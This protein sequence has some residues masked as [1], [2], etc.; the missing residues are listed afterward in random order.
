MNIGI[1]AVA[2]NRIESIKRLLNSIEKASYTEDVTLIISIDKS[3]TDIVEKYAYKFNWTH[4]DKR[5]VQHSENL[6]LRAHMLSLGRYFNEFDALIVLEDDITV[7]PS[8]YLYSKACVLKYHMDKNIA[9]ISL[10]SPRMSYISLHP[11]TPSVNKYDVYFIKS[12]FS[13][14]EVWMKNQW[15]EFIRW[16]NQNDGEIP[17]LA[18]IPKPITQWSNKSWLKYHITYCLKNNKYFVVPYIS[19]STNNAD[20][21]E[22][23]SVRDTSCQVAIL[24]DVK[25]DY[26]LPDE[27]HLGFHYDEFYEDEALYQ[28]LNLTEK[29]LILNLMCSQHNLR[30]KKYLLTPIVLNYKIIKQFGLTLKPISENIFNQCPGDGI[31]LYDTR[32]IEKNKNDTSLYLNEYLYPYSIQLLRRISGIRKILYFYMNKL[33]KKIWLYIK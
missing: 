2:Y 21:G 33:L 16:Y 32:I 28:A 5:V 23:I 14:G 18:S 3:D 22:H 15:L 9:G 12:A 20:K 27:V 13:W 4:G 25:Y 17:N 10:Y 30:Y 31:Y 24:N 19:L 7:S 8:F 1:V 29:E 11:F 26:Q 6:G